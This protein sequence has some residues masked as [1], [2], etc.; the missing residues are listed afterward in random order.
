MENGERAES[1]LLTISAEH[2]AREPFASCAWRSGVVIL[3]A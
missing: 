3:A 2:K 1:F